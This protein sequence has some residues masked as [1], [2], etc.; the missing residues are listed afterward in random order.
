[1]NS[2]NMHHLTQGN[3][4]KRTQQMDSVCESE[5]NEEEERG[6]GCGRKTGG[7]VKWWLP[8]KTIY[9]VM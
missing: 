9:Y 8:L 3:A 2:C 6:G 4:E 7:V 1:M 5:S